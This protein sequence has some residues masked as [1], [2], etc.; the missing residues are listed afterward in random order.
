[1]DH[2]NKYITMNVLPRCYANESNLP[3]SVELSPLQIEKRMKILYSN[4][5]LLPKKKYTFNMY[6]YPDTYFHKYVVKVKV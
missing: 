2:S 6:N 5:I 4:I 1:M 3:C